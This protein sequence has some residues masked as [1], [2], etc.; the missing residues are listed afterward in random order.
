MCYITDTLGNVEPLSLCKLQVG[1]FFSQG[2][3]IYFTKTQTGS[4]AMFFALFWILFWQEV[5]MTPLF[6]SPRG[7]LAK[8]RRDQ[9]TRGRNTGSNHSSV[10]DLARANYHILSHFSI[11]RVR[12]LVHPDS[13]GG[14]S[15]LAPCGFQYTHYHYSDELLPL[16]STFWTSSCFPIYYLHLSQRHSTRATVLILL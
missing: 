4:R 7:I 5:V 12:V 3:G 10:T 15:S 1:I 13:R 14:P 16:S 11:C 2:Q 9:Q 6:Q 8:G